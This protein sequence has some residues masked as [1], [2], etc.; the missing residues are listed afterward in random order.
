MKLEE[1]EGSC[2]YPKNDKK[3]MLLG[4]VLTLLYFYLTLIKLIPIY[5]LAPVLWI[6]IRLTHFSYLGY[7]DLLFTIYHA[8]VKECIKRKLSMVLYKQKCIEKYEA[9]PI[10]KRYTYSYYRS[11]VSGLHNMLTVFVVTNLLLLTVICQ[12]RILEFNAYNITISKPINLVKENKLIT[13][14]KTLEDIIN[15]NLDY[16]ILYDTNGETLF[17][18]EDRPQL[19]VVMIHTEEDE[20][21]IAYVDTYLSEILAVEQC[22]QN[23][24]IAI[25]I[26]DSSIPLTEGATD[27]PKWII[28]NYPTFRIVHLLTELRVYSVK[29]NIHGTTPT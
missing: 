23:K 10:R 21:L 25:F 28:K 14:S 29:E 18:I 20:E 27:V 8:F 13:I 3:L 24:Y 15:Q 1:F 22:L 7:N 4:I 17:Y 6:G 9:V 2:R 19:G 26:K 11:A 16:T 12:L 5:Y